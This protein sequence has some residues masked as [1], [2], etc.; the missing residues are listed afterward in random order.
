MT[1]HDPA[2]PPAPETPRPPLW[3]Q[4]RVWGGGT[5]PLEA[6]YDY[7]DA[8][9]VMIWQEAGG[10]GVGREVGTGDALHAD[11]DKVPSPARIQPRPPPPPAPTA[12]C[13]PLSPLAPQPLR[14]PPT[15]GTRPSWPT[16]AQRS[17]S[18]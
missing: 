13:C 9:G 2:L 6:L 16:C 14:A 8:R 1:R 15:P 3:R 17:S 5:Y 18:R 10:S 4:V 11:A 7:A 12:A